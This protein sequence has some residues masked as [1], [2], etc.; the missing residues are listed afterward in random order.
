MVVLLI[1][2]EKGLEVPY[3]MAAKAR[4][5]NGETIIKLENVWKIYQM[6]EVEVP[7]LRGITLDIKRGDFVAIVGAS[8]SGKS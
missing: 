7:A 8:G 6:G 5:K 2:G 4:K 1:K 3:Q